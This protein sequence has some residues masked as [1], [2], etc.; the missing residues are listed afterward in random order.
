MSSAH[1]R[2]SRTYPLK[3]RLKFFRFST[4]EFLDIFAVICPF[5]GLFQWF[6]AKTTWETHP[7]GFL[8][9]KKGDFGLFGIFF[10]N[11]NDNFFDNPTLFRNLFLKGQNSLSCAHKFNWISFPC[12]FSSEP[13]EKTKK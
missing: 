2:L 3:M 10:Q 1:S 11:I 6:R 5:F 8:S 12:R 13:L 7:T 4:M 9:Q